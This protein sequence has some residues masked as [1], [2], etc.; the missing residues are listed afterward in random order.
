MKETTFGVRERVV[1]RVRV[2]VLIAMTY[3]GRQQ[4]RMKIMTPQEK[5][6]KLKGLL[7]SKIARPV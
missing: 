4:K 1:G 2:P 7:R 5:R 3:S 6:R